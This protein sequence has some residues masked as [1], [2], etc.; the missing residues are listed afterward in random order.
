MSYDAITGQ[1]MK[2]YKLFFVLIGLCLLA[3]A[4][5]LVSIS[6]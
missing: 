5:F 2:K 6:I 4:L 1:K 3:S